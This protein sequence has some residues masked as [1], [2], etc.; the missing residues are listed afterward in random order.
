MNRMAPIAVAALAFACISPRAEAHSHT[1]P[2]ITVAMPLPAPLP[3]MHP[4]SCPADQHSACYIGP[5]TTSPGGDVF[6][7]DDS[8]GGGRFLRQHE[9]GHAYARLMLVD[10]ERNRITRAIGRVR[11][12]SERFA[13]FY[14]GCRL[15]LD[16]TFPEFRLGI[17]GGVKAA[18]VP[19]IC[20]LIARAGLN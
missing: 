13:D 2:R 16:P 15:H 19:S 6:Y 7:E 3:V 18:R 8:L 12:P 17:F 10:G 14:A 11:W 9:L 20:R 4:E 1:K 5:T